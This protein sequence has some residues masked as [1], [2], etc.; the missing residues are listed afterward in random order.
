MKNQKTKGKTV[1]NQN[2]LLTDLSKETTEN[3]SWLLN[4]STKKE[5]EILVINMRSEHNEY[6]DT[7]IEVDPNQTVN[8]IIQIIDSFIDETGFRKVQVEINALNFE[9]TSCEKQQFNLSDIDAY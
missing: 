7:N 8:E 4:D 9:F 5:I 3:N 1:S 6:A 2:Q